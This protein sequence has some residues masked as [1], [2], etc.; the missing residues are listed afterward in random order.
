LRLCFDL[1]SSF[2]ILESSSP[3]RYSWERA[4][5]CCPPNQVLLILYILHSYWWAQTYFTFTIP[6]FNLSVIIPDYLYSFFLHF[7]SLELL[8][9]L[10][11]F[12]SAFIISPKNLSYTTALPSFRPATRFLLTTFDFRICIYFVRP[13]IHLFCPVCFSLPSVIVLLHWLARYIMYLVFF[14]PQLIIL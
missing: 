10:I 2:L 12:H 3:R 5:P 13:F 4:L 8:C 11:H 9:S 7:L 14:V 6:S 1:L